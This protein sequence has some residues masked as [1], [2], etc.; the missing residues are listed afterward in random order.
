MTQGK[1]SAARKKPAAKPAAAKAARAK[2][3]AAT[4][5]A[6]RRW[7]IE[8]IDD[9]GASRHELGATIPDA[10]NSVDNETGGWRT[11]VPTIDP[12]KCTGCMLCYFYCPDAA[13]VIE[14]DVATGIDLAHCKGCGI[15]AAECPV[16]AITMSV[17]EKE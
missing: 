4:V 8:G 7:D 13:I 17:E 16:D 3:G 15:C 14:N 1:K 9:W 6:A 2:T 5:T 11:N 12:T 10:G